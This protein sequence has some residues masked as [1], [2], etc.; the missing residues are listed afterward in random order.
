MLSPATMLDAPAEAAM[1]L[2]YMDG[3]L[4][5]GC[6]LETAEGTE[7]LHP[8]TASFGANLDPLI[9][10]PATDMNGDFHMSQITRANQEEPRRIKAYL[11]NLKDSKRFPGGYSIFEHCS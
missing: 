5:E 7:F 3:L 10:W 4:L 8:S 1:D 9:A 6:W 2:D 11:T